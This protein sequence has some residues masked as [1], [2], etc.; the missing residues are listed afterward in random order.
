LVLFGIALGV[1]TVI[2]TIA[3]N[4][5]II[6]S[7][8][9]MVERVA[10]KAD[11][12]ISRGEAGV[13]AELIEELRE[14]EGI[15]H[16]AGS[17][18]ITTRLISGGG[19]LLVLGVDFLGDDHFLPLVSSAGA[20]VVDDPF[21]LVNDPNAILISRT[22]SKRTGIGVDG[23]MQLLTPDGPHDFVVRGLL[24]D[25]GLAASFGG[26]VALM[27]SEAAQLAFGR[28]G[29]VD[30]IDVALEEG[31]ERATVERSIAAVV[32]DRARVERPEGRTSHL[33]AIT[34]PIRRALYAA[35]AIALLVGMFLIY[36]AVSVSVAQ[37]Q[38]EIGVLRALG[39]T[40]RRVIAMFAVEACLLSALGGVLGIA[41]GYGLS[42]IA[43]AQTAPTISRFYA[44]VRPPPPEITLDLAVLGIAL[45]IF[46]TLLAAYFPAREAARVSPVEALRKATKRLTLRT[47]PHRSLL[48]VS[49][50]I[51]L[52]GTAAAQF[53]NVW[54]SLG[55]MFLILGAG[56]CAVPF[57][58][59]VLHK[60][61]VGPAE[62]LFGVPGRI[63]LDNTQR[64]L[65][66]SALTVGALMTSISSSVSVGA[67][68]ESLQ[69]SIWAWLDHSL[70][71]DLYV[72]SGSFIA[73][74]HNVPFKPDVM[75]K[76]AGTPGVHSMYP[77]RLVPQDVGERRVQVITV[78]MLEY[79]AQLE[80]KKM[81]GRTPSD[82]P[83]KIDPQILVDTPSVVLAENA[84][85][86]LQ[87][88][89]GETIVFETASG[90]V[91][92]KVY[93]VVAD[94]TSDQG[95]CLMDHKWYLEY[96]KD[97]LI[98]TVDIF[99]EDGASAPAVA[100][101]I[102]KRIGGGDTLF[103]VSAAEVRD[104]IRNVIRQSL[105]IF[106]STDFVALAVALLGVIGTMLAAV[107]D[108][109]R[110]IG[111]LRAIGATRRQVVSAIMIESG[112]LGLAAALAGVLTGV[113]MGYVFVRVAGLVGTGWKIEYVFPTEGALRVGILVILTATFAG[114]YPGRKAAKMS[115]PEAL[116]YE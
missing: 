80:R 30:R 58:L 66:R 94:Y 37:R 44:A 8:A 35:G 85:V 116:A 11:L 14:V 91:E 89:A 107:I 87:K 115:V 39:V 9:D 77:V 82:G 25:E 97:P 96:W 18:E 6:S 10:G 83:R 105:A 21:S 92:F 46:S 26:Q 33:E 23:T 48:W 5:S 55:S 20:D 1:A 100:E 65:G 52:V 86:R 32:R 53:E 84:A 109:I 76:L 57:A 13:P 102:R 114:L 61:L 4:R 43:L 78:D 98:D 112:F 71:A 103:V 34:G 74:Q 72:T 99:L 47:L 17:L 2:A 56:L 75:A 70:P 73:D 64:S 38:K 62:R 49:G 40:Q 31:A 22:L 59:V 93:A 110:E 45:G 81:S 42:I 28:E 63:G 51:L 88:K 15:A 24:E 95:T 79:Y 68:G 7:F 27:F 54:T 67:W 3:V 113:P 108:R 29:K 60:I 41:L 69:D 104:E 36:N 111:V 12:I 16:V 19:P 50:G 101:E 90:L 106:D